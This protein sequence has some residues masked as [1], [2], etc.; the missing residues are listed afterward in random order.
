MTGPGRQNDLLVIRF[1]KF[2]PKHSSA[3]EPVPPVTTTTATTK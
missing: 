2:P 3:D 1:G